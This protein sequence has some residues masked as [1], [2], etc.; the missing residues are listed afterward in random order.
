MKILLSVTLLIFCA[1]SASDQW[2][3]G[4]ARK[5]LKKEKIT[6]FVIVSPSSYEDENNELSISQFFN[7][8]HT[9]YDWSITVVDH[10]FN[11]M[12]G[13]TNGVVKNLILFASS[14]SDIDPVFRMVHLTNTRIFIFLTNSSCESVESIF[15]K[16]SSEIQDHVVVLQKIDD[17]FCKIQKY[18]CDDCSP[19][20]NKSVVVAAKCHDRSTALNIRHL[21]S[22]IPAEGK[23]CPL[24]VATK[25]FEHFTYYTTTSKDFTMASTI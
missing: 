25:Q 12:E 1:T 2:P 10:I 21:P 8:L 14:P 18:V 4:C 15:K 16:F 5:L 13:Q 17:N 24:I 23:S 3:S 11:A 6:N 7:S 20:G 19:N 9:K 22:G